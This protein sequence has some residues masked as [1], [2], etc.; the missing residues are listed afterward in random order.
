M[1]MINETK[2]ELI[3]QMVVLRQSR[4]ITQTQLSE[5]SGIKQPVIARLESGKTDPQ[6]STVLK[7]LDCMDAKLILTTEGKDYNDWAGT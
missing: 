7:L 3:R 1:K 5:A 4:K 2:A 6:L